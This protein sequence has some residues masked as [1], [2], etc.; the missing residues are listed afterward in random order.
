MPANKI[1]HEIYVGDLQDALNWDGNL[2]CVLE[3]RPKDEPTNALHIPIL[4]LKWEKKENADGYV[5]KA[6][7]VQLDA[8][9]HVIQNHIDAKEKL[10]V[11]C[12][13]GM[14]RSPL[15]LTWYLHT[16]MG[17]TLEEAFEFVKERRPQAQNRLEWI[18]GWK[19][20]HFKAVKESEEKFKTHTAGQEIDI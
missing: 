17:L 20:R 7:T 15:A 19:E 3:E 6:L 12:G 11:H 18:S 1:I 8:V 4:G 16:R 14:E 2:L 9:A 5:D 13:A 10:L